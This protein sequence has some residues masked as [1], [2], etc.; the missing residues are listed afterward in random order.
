MNK[1]IVTGGAGYLGS[2]TCLKLIEEGY[3]P[4]VI[5]NF[6]NTNIKNIK[7]IENIS[8]KP[9]RFHKID[10]NITE[11]VNNVLKN[12]KGIIGA[13]HFAG[14]KSVEESLREPEK[15][16]KNN[17]GSL[18]SLIEVFKMNNFNN[19]IFSSSC[20]VY[21]NPDSLPVEENAPFKKD[22]SPYG[23][24]KQLCEEMIK[25]SKLFSVRLRYFNP[26]GSHKSGLIGDRSNDKP[27]NL[28]PIMCE[29][30][31][32]KRGKLI[33][34]GIDYKTKD[35][36][37]V[38]DY[39]HVEDL[40]AAHTNALSY[41]IKNQNQ[42]VFNIGT[43]KGLSVLETIKLFEKVN[44]MKLNYEFGPRRKGDI[45]KIYSN[46]KKSMKLLKWKSNKTIEE[47]LKS[48]WEWEIK[49]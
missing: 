47:A 5:D 48:S 35:G 32:G 38:R 9:L 25:E 41:C 1:V 30:A 45:A 6:S 27:T 2:H 14:F 7:G 28:V 40:A 24:T 3:I 16:F 26:I 8:R 46:T 17:L 12:E 43:G 37:C 21:G 33:V 42:S 10:C 29:V 36:S 19:I 22:I 49:K 39:I 31:S 34:N 20:T 18:K 11:N 15:Y 13:I 4:I 23:K 44:E